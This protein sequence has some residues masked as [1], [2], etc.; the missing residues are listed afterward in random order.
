[1]TSVPTLGALAKVT[2]VT[3]VRGGLIFRT[4]KSVALP[5]AKFGCFSTPVIVDGP[6]KLVETH[7]VRELYNVHQDPDE[8]TNLVARHPEIAYRL[9]AMLG[10]QRARARV[11]AFD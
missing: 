11:S 2:G 6:W 3:P 10:A 7:G 8:R 4:A 5:Q 9:A 1:M